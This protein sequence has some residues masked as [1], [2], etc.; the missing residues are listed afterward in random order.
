VKSSD[1]RLPAKL[2]PDIASD[3]ETEVWATVWRPAS[4]NAGPYP[5]VLFLHGNHG[6]CGRLDPERGI[7]VDDRIDYTFTGKCPRGYTVTP[8]H[9]G[10]AYLAERLAARGYVVVS[11]NAN[12]GVTSADGVN[13]DF[14]LNLRRGRLVLR[15]LEQLRQWN[16]RG[17]APASLGF[18]LR[19]KL[20][21]AQVGLVG[22]SRGGEGMRAAL[23]LYHDAG[24]PWPARL[25][26]IG[27]RA[28]FEIGPVD[29]QTN[30][31]LDAMGVA[32][33]VLL[34]FCDGDV[35]TLEGVRP[36]DRMLLRRQEKAPLPKSTVGVYGANHNFFNTEWQESDSYGCLGPGNK[37]LFPKVGGSPAQQEAAIATIVPFVQAHVG[38]DARPED[39]G[40][41]N[42]DQP[43][44]AA[45]K[46]ITRVE[47][48][49]TDTPDRDIVARLEDFSRP[50]GMSSNGQ[51]NLARGITI[52]HGPVPSHDDRQRAAAIS[53]S[54]NATGFFQTNLSPVGGGRGLAGFKTLE[55]RVSRQCSDFCTRPNPLNAGGPTD[56]TI[57]L[58]RAN[59]SLST[60]VPLA[61][62]LSLRGP[63]GVSMDPFGDFGEFH[64]I[65]A[66]ARI[67]LGAFGLGANETFRGVRFTFDR[68]AQGAIYLANI[69]LSSRS[70]AM[71][72]QGAASSGS[73][74][75]VAAL[76]AVAEPAPAARAAA[77]APLPRA[78][79][80]AVRRA[81][82][83]PGPALRSAAPSDEIEI[84]IAAD[85]PLPVTDAL[86]EITIGGK[87]AQRSRFGGDGGTERIIFTLDSDDFAALPDG[88]PVA[89]R[90]GA[91]HRIPVGRLDKSSL[92]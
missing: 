4:L 64:P 67:P 49:Y 74:A 30:R 10:Y 84:E 80:V 68:S 25:G 79:I 2:D 5:L 51:P 18:D 88:A 37:P 61:S 62:Y 35:S 69:R 7:R 70:A 14:G 28:L 17:G 31:R 77:P 3:V 57:Q 92:R 47:R 16:D 12:R 54:G 8:S 39:G 41:F 53:W 36:F 55:F 19:R 9:L 24:S 85:R 34:P 56:F 82:T 87:R 44:P 73:R 59:G 1:Y 26:E 81:G 13:G 42:P 91:S 45:L 6:T 23:A 65:L 66:T 46:S 40:L 63:A 90:L 27:F 86:P 76:D 20:D 43:L 32:W 50:T 33:T 72:A 29:G 52:K 58:V 21:F 78:S 22:H 75:A 15:H 71:N 83:G 48:G 89:L 11:I 60:G 38:R